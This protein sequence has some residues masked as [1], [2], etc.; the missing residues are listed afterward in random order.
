MVCVPAFLQRLPTLTDPDVMKSVY[1]V[2]PQDILYLSNLLH[3]LL[4][5]AKLRLLLGGCM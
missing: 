2:G 1:G 5:K 3:N 4:K